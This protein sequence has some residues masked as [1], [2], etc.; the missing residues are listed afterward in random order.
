MGLRKNPRAYI[1]MPTQP[2]WVTVWCGLW[3]RGI[4]G[5]FFFEN[6]QGEAFVV[7]GD[8]FRAI[9]NEFLFT[10]IEEEDIGNIS[11]QQDGATCHRAEATLDVLRPIFE[12][13]IIRSHWLPRS[14]DLTLLDYY[15]WGV[16]KDNCY[17]D[18]PETIDA[19]KDNI[20]EPIG[21]I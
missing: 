16:P 9:F 21:E 4:I 14:C 13:W 6:E 19:L 8:R 5:P 12:D 7:N 15:L 1:E 10:K 2:K 3:C 18:K 20:R 17:N 11:L